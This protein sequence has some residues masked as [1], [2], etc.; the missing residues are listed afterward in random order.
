MAPDGATRGGSHVA[1]RS[2]PRPGSHRLGH[3]RSGPIEELG[4][5][6]KAAIDRLRDRA[7]E[8]RFYDAY[9]FVLD[10]ETLVVGAGVYLE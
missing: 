6:G 2:R 1:Q 4:R 9:V 10:G 3:L 8:Y 5:H 7:G